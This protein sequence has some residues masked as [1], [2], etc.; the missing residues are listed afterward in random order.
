MKFCIFELFNIKFYFIE[1]EYIIINNID[2]T[3]NFYNHFIED[4]KNISV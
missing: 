2:Y 1:K 4:L 3:I